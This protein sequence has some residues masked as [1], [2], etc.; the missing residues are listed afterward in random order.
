MLVALTRSDFDFLV[1][2]AIEAST[3]QEQLV[4]ILTIEG[5]DVNTGKVDETR[6]EV[7][8]LNESTEKWMPGTPWVRW[9]K[10]SDLD[11]G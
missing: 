11:I 7:N 10:F 2:L 6:A 8:W 1:A 3:T 5:C 4:R 9:A